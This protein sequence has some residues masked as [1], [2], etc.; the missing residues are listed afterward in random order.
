MVAFFSQVYASAN[1]AHYLFKI[2]LLHL[3]RDLNLCCRAI[4]FPASVKQFILSIKIQEPSIMEKEF[5]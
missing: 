1:L 2:M 4:S 3:A 5:L